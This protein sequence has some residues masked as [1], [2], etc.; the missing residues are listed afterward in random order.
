MCGGPRQF[1]EA[2]ARLSQ[3]G[4]VMTV[5]VVEYFKHLRPKPQRGW[6]GQ[7][8]GW[9]MRQLMARQILTAFD[10]DK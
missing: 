5:M 4:N 10:S 2:R 7:K 3:L 8:T 9:C 1:V 6:S